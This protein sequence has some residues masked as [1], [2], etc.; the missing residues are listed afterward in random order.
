MVIPLTQF[1]GDL[2]RALSVERLE[3]YRPP[4]GD[5]LEMLTNYF[6]NMDLAE[7]LMPALHGV[8]LVTSMRR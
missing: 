5:D 6:W 3:S 2:H 8:E 4:N 7:G 1:I